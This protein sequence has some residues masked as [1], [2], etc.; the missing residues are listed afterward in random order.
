MIKRAFV[1]DEDVS[2]RSMLWKIFER[3]GYKVFTYPRPGA[4]PGT[5]EFQSFC[6]SGQACGDFIL[7][8]ID[9]EDVTRL[10]F[11]QEQI[12]RGCKV[13]NIGLIS[14]IWSESDLRI[15]KDLRCK[16]FKK[17]ITGDG[18]NV[19]IDACEEKKRP[20]KALF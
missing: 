14:S 20:I 6:L 15:A 17:P 13:K 12:K 5:L 19:W 1:F 7:T 18:I 4:C 16:V 9:I 11:I 3:R 2:I 8:N 10:G